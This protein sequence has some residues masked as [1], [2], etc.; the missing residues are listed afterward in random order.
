MTEECCPK[1]FH[2]KGHQDDHKAY[3][4]LSLPA[5]LNVDADALANAYVQQ[6]PTKDYTRA[7]MLPANGA[8]L[9]LPQGTV[10][11]QLKT[12]IQKAQTT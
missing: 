5:Q 12:A 11:F 10:T 1:I 9:H 2:I 4:E 6:N 7:P 8:Q 3:D